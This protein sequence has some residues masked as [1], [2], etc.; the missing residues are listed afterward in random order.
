VLRTSNADAPHLRRSRG[1]EGYAI[2]REAGLVP[3]PELTSRQEQMVAGRKREEASNAQALGG[4][5]E[6]IAATERAIA[7][8]G[9]GPFAGTMS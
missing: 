4:M 2:I 3:F 1:S 8:V 7:A 6:T 5:G 9:G